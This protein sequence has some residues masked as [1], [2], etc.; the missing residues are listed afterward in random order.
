MTSSTTM[1][2]GRSRPTASPSSCPPDGLRSFRL[3]NHL[4]S[5]VEVSDRFHVQPLLRTVTVPQSAYVLALAQNSVRLVG[6]SLRSAG[7]G[8]EAQRHA[9]GC[10]WP[11]ARK[12]SMRDRS[13]SGRLQGS[14][15]MKV[16]QAQYARKW[17]RPC[18]GC[19]WARRPV[20]PGGH[21][22][23]AIDLPRD[24]VYPHLG[25]APRSCTTPRCRAM[26]SW[27]PNAR[28]ILDDSSALNS[29]KSSRC[30]PCAPARGA[31]Q[32]IWPRRP[33]QPPTAPFNCC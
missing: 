25:R 20:D 32:P 10:G 19:W 22:T 2:S 1:T 28:T 24:S 13:P 16:R 6:V 18:G 17:I 27:R 33:A 12:S 29:L 11:A 7:G 8:T 23:D 31:P 26:T 15:G 9:Q 4:K 3:P 5:A 30:T 21:R 14:E